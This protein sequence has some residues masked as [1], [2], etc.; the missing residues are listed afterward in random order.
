MTKA[1]LSDT[2][3]AEE[4]NL[5]DLDLEADKSAAISEISPI[6]CAAKQNTSQ[7]IETLGK[8]TDS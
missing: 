2:L 3:V 8:L 5:S 4:P 6:R 1:H 7:K